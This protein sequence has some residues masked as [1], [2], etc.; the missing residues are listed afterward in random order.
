MI[1]AV[2][3]NHGVSGA[4]GVLTTTLATAPPQRRFLGK[5]EQPDRNIEKRYFN[6]VAAQMHALK[7]GFQIQ[8]R[9]D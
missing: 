6:T 4:K 2:K 3:L 8:S 9:T 7:I 5:C 1:D